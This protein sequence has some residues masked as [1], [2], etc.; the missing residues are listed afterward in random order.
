MQADIQ[1]L[2]GAGG[3]GL[4]ARADLSNPGNGYWAGISRYNL[5]A[6]ITPGANPF[7][8]ATSNSDFLS[9]IAFDPGQ[10]WHTF[11]IEVKT[12]T[13]TFLV[14]GNVVAQTT[15]NRFLSGGAVGV[16]F[17]GGAQLAIRNLKVIALGDGR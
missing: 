16:F 12:D 11:R 9:S 6:G 5:I 10:E 1:F 17:D 8:D 3:A 7:Y 15:D 2:G 14:D 4:V 13:V